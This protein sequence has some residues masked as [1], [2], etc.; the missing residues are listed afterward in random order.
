MLFYSDEDKQLTECKFCHKPCYKTKRVG[1]GKHKY[2]PMKK[3]N[4][5][6]LI[7]KLRRLYALMSF[8]PHMR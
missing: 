5:L 2:V 7:P 6:P 3:M 8:A 4:Y 1:R